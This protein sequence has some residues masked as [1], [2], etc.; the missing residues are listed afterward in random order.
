[1]C[2]IRFVW[3]QSSRSSWLSSP[4]IQY[5][6]ILVSLTLDSDGYS[7]LS[8]LRWYSCYNIQVCPW[9]KQWQSSPSLQYLRCKGMTDWRWWWEVST[10]TFSS[11]W[12]N[13]HNGTKMKDGVSA[14]E[15]LM[16]FCWLFPVE[17]SASKG[18]MV[19]LQWR[20]IPESRL[21]CISWPWIKLFET[22]KSRWQIIHHLLIQPRCLSSFIVIIVTNTTNCFSLFLDQIQL[23]WLQCCCLCPPSL[24]L[25]PVRCWGPALF[26]F[27][28]AFLRVY[29]C[30]RWEKGHP[31]RTSTRFYRDVSLDI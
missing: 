8:P 16:T 5:P 9:G 24:N 30:Q 22:D 19:F 15:H 2:H 6:I 20:E 14:Q 27:A 4:A 7:T 12:V 13:K 3:V 26:G 21:F 1:M 31:R 28:V 11:V 23:W 17:I 25:V 10:D 18:R 29:H